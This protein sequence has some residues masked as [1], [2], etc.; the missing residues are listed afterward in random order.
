MPL[1]FH[2]AVCT[3]LYKKVILFI[4][5]RLKLHRAK[6]VEGLV[7]VTELR[8]RTSC[9]NHLCGDG[10]LTPLAL[11]QGGDCSSPID[12]L[13][14]L[15]LNMSRTNRDDQYRSLDSPHPFGSRA[16]TLSIRLFFRNL[17]NDGIPWLDVSLYPKKPLL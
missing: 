12:S 10:N 2:Y 16:Y 4:D 9:W 17:T 14:A 13:K 5:K 1:C 3:M 11:R 15:K 6:D 7:C 8:S